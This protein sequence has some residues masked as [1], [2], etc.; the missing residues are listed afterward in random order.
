VTIDVDK[1]TEVK[2]GTD[3]RIR[4]QSTVAGTLILF[5]VDS[6]GKLTQLFPNK[7]SATR[8]G[9]LQAWAQIQPGVPLFVPSLGDSFALTVDRPYGENRLIAVIAPPNTKGLDLLGENDRLEPVKDPQAL[10]GRVAQ[11]LAEAREAQ[12]SVNPEYMGS[13]AI[14]VRPTKPLIPVGERAYRVVP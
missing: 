9:A 1:G 12:D 6:S 2:A 3:I 14:N 13:R 5:D 8:P 11:R 7:F 4:V 10:L